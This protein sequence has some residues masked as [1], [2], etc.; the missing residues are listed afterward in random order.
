M[1]FNPG[2]YNN[3]NSQE[4]I[5][6]TSSAPLTNLNIIRQVSV[7]RTLVLL[8][9]MLFGLTLG[10][11]YGNDQLRTAYERGVTDTQKCMAR[12]V[13]LLKYH[14]T[15]VIHVHDHHIWILP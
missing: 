14:V 9:A 12:P 7:S 4:E 10:Q 11:L 8:F 1:N 6:N 15:N 2:I 3:P 5:M 13:V